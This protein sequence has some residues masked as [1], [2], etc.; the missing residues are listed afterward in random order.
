VF[1]FNHFKSFLDALQVNT[2]ERGVVTLGT[3]LLGP[4]KRLLQEMQRG[5]EDGQREFI[6]LKARQLGISTLSLALDM[7]WL[8]RFDGT[9]GALITHDE[10][11]REQF[12]AIFELYYANLPDMWKQSIVQHNRNQLLLENRSMLQ[13][14]VAGLKQTSTKTLGRSSAISF[15]HFTEVAYWGDPQ[16]IH[17]LKAS[18]AEHNPL[19]LFQ[20]ESTAN[21]F[22]HF[23]DMWDDALSSVTQCAIF[24]GWWSHEFYRASRD[25]RI[26]KQYWGVKGKPTPQEAST[27]ARL[28]REYDHELDDEQLAWYRWMRAEKVTDE[29]ALMA[30]YPTF[31]DEAFVATGSKFFTGQAI[32]ENYKQVLR[33]PA[34]Q[35]FRIHIG[36]E[37][38][39][40]ELREVPERLA[41]LRV[42]EEPVPGAFYCL[43]G[44]PA[45]GSSEASDRFA[46]SVLRAYANRLEQVAEFCTVDIAPYTFAW[47]IVYL[48]GCYQ[49]CVY[50]LEVNGPG[51]A[52]I[53]EIDNLRKMAGRS[54]IPGQAKTMR[55]VVGK[56]QQ[57]LFVREDS[58]YR[59]PTGL[60]TLTTQRVKDVYMSGLKDVLE[61][62]VF[63]PHSKYLL[64]EM[65]TVIRDGGVIEASGDAHDDRV[66]SA[67][68]AV[69][70]WND[71]LRM[72]LINQNVIWV[73]P[74]KRAQYEP[75]DLSTQAGRTSA[76]VGRQLRTYLKDI[77]VLHT[78]KP[79]TGVKA[80]NVEKIPKGTTVMR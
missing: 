40:T 24:I 30:E 8:F 35:S 19:R 9:P 64:D 14:K 36:Q 15:G 7:Y 59:R 79:E 32:T 57:F 44:D 34:P 6:T 29:M 47:V 21:G 25:T 77:G 46:I 45:Y 10:P 27:A 5:M 12:R 80:Y 78:P 60:H 61:R 70:A 66:V 22:N 67:A 58:L 33:Q 18:M 31:P 28:K 52:V 38:T 76:V 75:P 39:D 17:S 4:Q 37:F 62:G 68:L 54:Y 41:T 49:P 74:E 26:W 71:Q 51:G 65:K 69:K 53:Q 23:Y 55:D 48:A 1:D 72:R 50:N 13:Y 3:S 63:V 42:W 56:M 16:Q 11:A 43:G 20:W 73:P 2:K